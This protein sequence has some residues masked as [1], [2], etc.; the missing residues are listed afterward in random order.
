[1]ISRFKKPSLVRKTSEQL[2]E[3]GLNFCS[4]LFTGVIARM[5]KNALKS[6]YRFQFQTMH[7]TL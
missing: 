6:V 1:M 5:Q 3:Q 2:T 4:S 7:C